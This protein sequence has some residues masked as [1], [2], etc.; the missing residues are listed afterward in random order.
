MDLVS[1][2]IFE[3]SHELRVDFDQLLV[4]IDEHGDLLRHRDKVPILVV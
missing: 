1:L 2:R 3:F 4:F